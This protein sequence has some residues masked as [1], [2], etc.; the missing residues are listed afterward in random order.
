MTNGFFTIPNTFDLVSEFI[1]A[2][3]SIT[4]SKVFGVIIL[5]GLFYHWKS[6]VRF[7]VGGRVE[8][9][10]FSL[11]HMGLAGHAGR[12][13]R[14]RADDASAG[15]RAV[16][17]GEVAGGAVRVDGSATWWTGQHRGAALPGVGQSGGRFDRMS[18]VWCR[19]ATPPPGRSPSVGSV[20]SGGMSSNRCQRGWGGPVVSLERA[21]GA[22]CRP[23]CRSATECP[24]GW[25]MLASHAAGI[26]VAGSM[27]FP[28]RS[29]CQARRYVA[30]F[31]ELLGRAARRSFKSAG[32]NRLGGGDGRALRRRASNP[33]RPR[34]MRRRPARAWRSVDRGTCRP[35]Y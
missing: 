19:P 35:G 10:Y 12:V 3:T 27:S 8:R 13:G 6:P 26:G 4:M 9:A 1:H 16:T 25:P 30:G 28:T 31:A 7:T 15:R 34:V 21:P 29:P 5:K 14:L 33:R 2:S 11:V 20:G 24:D 32:I 23:T 18:V 17:F 22:A